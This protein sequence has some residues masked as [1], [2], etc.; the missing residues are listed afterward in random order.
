MKSTTKPRR[1]RGEVVPGAQFD[2]TLAEARPLA[3]E[4]CRRAVTEWEAAKE[5]QADGWKRQDESRTQSLGVKYD[6]YDDE[7]AEWERWCLVLD[8]FTSVAEQRLAA[9]ILVCCRRLK[10]PMH[11]KTTAE[12]LGKGWTPCAME[13]G[14]THYV[15]YPNDS[16]D[17]DWSPRVVV[18]PPGGFDSHD[19]G[20]GEWD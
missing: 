10:H 3:L 6:G 13:L 15:V 17:D 4:I 5:R 16:D 19:F 20:Q 8:H 9:A 2:H 18:V 11:G 1:L 7:F 14:D 12:T